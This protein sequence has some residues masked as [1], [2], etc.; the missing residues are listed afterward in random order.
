MKLVTRAFKTNIASRSLA[1][2]TSN[3]ANFYVCAAYSNSDIAIANT[4]NTIE[5][6]VYEF[7]KNIVF[8]NKLTAN[9]SIIVAKNIPWVEGNTYDMY[10]DKVVDLHNKNFYVVVDDFADSKSIFKCLFNG[11]I[12]TG[13]TYIV[14]GVT[15]RPTVTKVQPNDEYY[16][17][18]DG[19]VWKF[20]CNVSEEDVIKFSTAN[21]VPV[22]ANANVSA[23]AVNGSI[24]T[25]LIE[26]T[27]GN[28]Q[29]Y[30]IGNVKLANY[31]GDSS[32]VALESDATQALFTFNATLTT[33]NTFVVGLS[34]NVELT[35]VTGNTVLIGSVYSFS[36]NELKILADIDTQL[37][38]N[39]INNSTTAKVVQ[40]TSSADIFTV[41]KDTISSLSSKNG[42]YTGSAIYIRNGTGAGQ[43]RR[44][45]SYDIIGNDRVATLESG[46]TGDL[47]N[48]S[49]FE[50]APSVIVSGDGTGATAICHINSATNSV[51]AVEMVSR[52]SGYTFADVSLV[53]TSGVVDLATSQIISPTPAVLRAIISPK[54]GHGFDI[55][56]DLF[57]H[58][59]CI[60]KK[61][62]REEHPFTNEY[63]KICILA[64]P[65]FSNTSNTSTF[66]D[67]LLAN[68][69]VL[70]GTNFNIGET[71]TQSNTN[72][73]AIVH[74][75]SG[76]NVYFSGVRGDFSLDLDKTLIG[77]TS[78]TVVQLNGL[79]QPN[80]I[81]T[82]GQI[83]YIEDLNSPINRSSIQS[84]T[85]KI[86]IEY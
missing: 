7:D 80:R 72:F 16:R 63:N 48:T 67:R 52:G 21:Y 20:L 71:V 31:T 9:D 82:S 59:V 68:T 78:G 2:L 43:L 38:Q 84:E 40:G 27:G 30:A 85:I 15:D 86:V 69:S 39:E 44:I 3:T 55:F 81:K 41:Q 62:I 76:A 58:V 6:T 49:Q 12:H 46:F 77:E 28:Y 26:D 79:T 36:G 10:D 24:D 70:F 45:V 11:R 25:I 17:T 34:A 57:T 42:F 75:I 73:T 19:Y 18:A 56:T 29:S 14:A 74:E 51:R 61:F 47:D 37:S 50:I 23:N 60:S 8:G 4:T 83:L 33:S 64:N 66:D 1:Q 53:G 5:D 22:R 65:S 32:K 13:N 35:A 54:G